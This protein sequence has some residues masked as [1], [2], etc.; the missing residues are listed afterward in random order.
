MC[1]GPHGS[2]E[3]SPHALSPEQAAHVA[4]AL[5]LSSAPFVWAAGTLTVLPE[6]FEVATASRG[7]VIRGWAPQVEI[8]RHRAVGWF[9]MHCGMNT[10]LEAVSAGV[11]MLAWPM[12]A[13]HFINRVLLREAGV[14]IDVAEGA[15]AVPDAA[16]MA[17]AIAAAVGDEGKPIRE[18]AMELGCKAVAAVGRV[19]A[20]TGTCKSWFAFW[21]MSTSACR[22]PIDMGIF[23][24]GLPYRKSTPRE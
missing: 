22:P 5:A 8:L 23:L 2:G 14:A 13:D 24:F 17:K 10:L 21:L 12:G 20:L 16:Q 7:M 6:G 3:T 18:R 9:L 11:A 19:G 4:E 15:D 1:A